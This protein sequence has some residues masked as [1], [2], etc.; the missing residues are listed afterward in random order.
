MINAI[1]AI[2]ALFPSLASADSSSSIKQKLIDFQTPLAI[3]A[4]E[5]DFP[6]V[7]WSMAPVPTCASE[8]DQSEYD[9]LF[10]EDSMFI[11]GT[12]NFTDLK[13]SINCCRYLPDLVLQ[14]TI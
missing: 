5:E 9:A 14:S 8:A 12:F 3:E 2:A 13:V 10:E 4:L 6:D 7:D 1:L 11:Y